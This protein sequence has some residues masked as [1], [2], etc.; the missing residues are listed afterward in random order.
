M[1][2]VSYLLFVLQFEALVTLIPLMEVADKANIMRV[3][4]LQL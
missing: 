3:A 2:F 4:K 1:G